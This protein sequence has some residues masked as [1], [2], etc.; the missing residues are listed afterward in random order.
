MISTSPD[1]LFS[2]SFQRAAIGLDDVFLCHTCLWVGTR[3][4][5]NGVGGEIWERWE[6][7]ERWEVVGASTLNR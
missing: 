4:C 7:R 2:C 3:T 6:R 1:L 5:S